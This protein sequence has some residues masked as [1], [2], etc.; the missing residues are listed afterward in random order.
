MKNLFLAL[1]IVCFNINAKDMLIFKS[2]PRSSSYYQMSK[3]ISQIIKKKSSYQTRVHVVESLGSLE[4]IDEVKYRD[5]GKY[6]FSSADSIVK[7]SSIKLLFPLP[8]A[9]V[10]FV[11]RKDLNITNFYNLEGKIL[12]IGEGTY[13]SKIAKKYI[14]L[15]EF[16]D[17][18]ELL[19]I[20][21]NNIA[22]ALKNHEIDAF[23]TLGSFPATNVIATSK[24][25]DVDI[26]NLSDEQIMKTKD[27]KIIIPANTYKNIKKDTQTT[28]FLTGVY[29]TDKMSDKLAYNLTKYFW[30]SK[31][32]LEKLHV[33]WK[34]IKPHDIKIFN[35]KLHKGAL[36]YYKEIGINIQ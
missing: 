33:W 7:N 3:D 36:K 4:N 16:N 27:T 22:T 5:N 25:V 10:Q 1:I 26:L 6:I 13:G 15:F 23:L 18:I 12:L 21:L 30:N 19:E 14:N 9:T 20:N 2:A 17:K 35:T 28:T 29:T 34:Y 31:N 11:T 32:D 24:L 8:P